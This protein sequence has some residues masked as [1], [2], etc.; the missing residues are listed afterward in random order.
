M[1]QDIFYI[2]AITQ[3]VLTIIFILA[4]LFVVFKI[5]RMASTLV[6]TV[7]QKANQIN[8]VISEVG[9]QGSNL[10]KLATKEGQQAVSAST[11][12]AILMNGYFFL[13][14]IFGSKRK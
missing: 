14:T 1:L 8:D 13:K 9:E 12:L 2:V 4:L 11:I 7:N 5:Y 6:E 3:G 10:L